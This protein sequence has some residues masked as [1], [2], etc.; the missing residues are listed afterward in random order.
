MLNSIQ[1]PALVIDE[2]RCKRNINRMAEKASRNHC[3]FRPHFK[4]HQSRTVGRW[5]RE[6]GIKG[7]TVST[8]EMALYFAEDGWDDI[9]IG[10]PF[11][12]SQINALLELEKRSKLQ[13]FINSTEHLR[14]LG[15]QLRNPFKWYV[16]VD[17]GYGRSGI[18]Y[19]NKDLIKELVDQSDVLDKSQFK[20][21]Y[22]HDGRTYQARGKSEI[23]K[24]IEP[25]ISILK[26]L[27]EQFPSAKLSLGDTPSASCLDNFDGIDILTPGNLVF[28]DWM[29]VQI[30]S[31]SLDD[32]AV[33]A[34]LPI[35]QHIKNEKR[36][37]LHGGAVHLSKDFI[38]ESGKRNY[39]QVI[40]YSDNESIRPE[41]E[42]FLGSLSQEHG[43]INYESEISEEIADTHKVWVCPV[44]SCLTANL[45]DHYITTEGKKIEKR[46]LS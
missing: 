36:I 27:K 17:P 37:I 44:H 3:E 39:G 41:K 6:A 40:H 16:E 4:T 42:L 34:L 32:V 31:C 7:I 23:T 8:P 22:I 43:I 1:K 26:D 28:Y 21:F 20:G 18:H 25:V 45:F 33:F 9:T 35:A 11:H 14:L 10:F 38:T 46:V 2:N 29:Q 13:L 12:P 5:F 19:K 30:G 24:T 15:N